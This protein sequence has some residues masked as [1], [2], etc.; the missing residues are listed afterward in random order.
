[1]IVVHSS[2]LEA[3]ADHWVTD[4][5][6]QDAVW[7]DKAIADGAKRTFVCRSDAEQAWQRWRSLKR[8]K[9]S[10]WS[11]TGDIVLVN[12]SEGPEGPWTIRARRSETADPAVLAAERFRRSSFII[13]SNHPTHTPRYLLQAY[14]HQYVIEQDNAL[15]KGPLKIAPVF[16]KD[17]RKLEAYI[18][19]VFL[20]L[21]LWRCME[22]VMRVNQEHLG[23]T[24]PY[25]NQRLQPAPTTKRLKEIIQPVQV[26]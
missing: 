26:I 13:V 7:L 3:K 11:V 21:L 15:V 19:C 2:A 17:P 16:L 24:L 14:K 8:V 9:G 4:Q 20:A 6:N 23:I 18:Y 1:M 12:P 22:A 10:A 5:L 25:P